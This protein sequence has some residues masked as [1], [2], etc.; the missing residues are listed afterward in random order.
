MAPLNL[1]S[2][3]GACFR[4]RYILA[5]VDPE[6][7]FDGRIKSGPLYVG[8][9]NAYGFAYEATHATAEPDRAALQPG[10]SPRR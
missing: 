1:R 10:A 3:A 7:Q 9:A 2:R 6:R 5:L 8:M 4:F